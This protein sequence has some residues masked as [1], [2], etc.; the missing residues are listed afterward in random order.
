MEC[1]FA[2]IADS[3]QQDRKLHAL[4]IGWDTLYAPS[5]PSVHPMMSFVA[6]LEGSIAENGEKDMVLRL[7]DA[8]GVD[9]VPPLS[10]KIRLDV[11]PPR[12][13]GTINI[14]L[15][16]SGITFSK[17]GGYAFHLIVQG[18]E[19]ARVAFNIAMPPSTT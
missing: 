7:I 3:A 19:K 6:K 15:G 9:V 14:A 16:F 13:T 18:N 10:N 2:F 11:K 8:D 17:Y 5:L 1:Q 12:L 4:G